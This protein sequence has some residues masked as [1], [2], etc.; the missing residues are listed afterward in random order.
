MRRFEPT[1]QNVKSALQGV[2]MLV[3][4]LL[5]GAHVGAAWYAMAGFAVSVAFHVLHEVRWRGQHGDERILVVMAFWP[6]IVLA[7]YWIVRDEEGKRRERIV[8]EVMES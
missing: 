7:G 1:K 8:A 3:S 4:S 2:Y 5:V 6:S